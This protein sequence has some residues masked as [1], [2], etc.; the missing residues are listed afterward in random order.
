MATSDRRQREIAQ[1]ETLFIDTAKAILLDRGYLGLTMDRVAEATDYAKGTVYL[2]FSSKEDLVAAIQVDI[3]QTRARAFRRAAQFHG[4]PRER[5]CAVGV[6]DAAILHAQP[7]YPRLEQILDV[8]PIFERVSP[9]RQE[10]IRAAKRR[11]MDDLERIVTD[12]IDQG[13]LTLPDAVPPCSILYGLWSL[14]AGSCSI[15]AGQHHL[16]TPQL[17]A[18]DP[19]SLLWRSYNALL[20][21]YGWRPLGHEWDYATTI[22][23]IVEAIF[24]ELHRAGWSP[25]HA[26][27]P[28]RSPPR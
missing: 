25:T 16:Y 17:A 27:P 2:H 20:D 24:P 4:R 5:I 8:S 28:D 3:I 23:R 19:T 9:E 12:A 7:E 6:A 26:T 18:A 14:A 1:R 11:M 15:I 10:Q 21:G 13:D 22:E